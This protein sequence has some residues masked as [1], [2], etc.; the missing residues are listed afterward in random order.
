MKQF[1]DFGIKPDSKTFT[2][3]K[4]KIHKVMNKQIVIEDYRITPSKFNDPGDQ[5]LQMQ[6]VVDDVKR[7]IFT[8]SKPLMSLIE[9]VPKTEFP[10]LAMIIK[11]NDSYEFQ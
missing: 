6:V 10:F 3:E 5:C 9:R 11:E 4:I 7:V 2:G 8:G 1:K